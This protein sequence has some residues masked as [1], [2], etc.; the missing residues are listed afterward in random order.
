MASNIDASKPISG[1]PTTASVR[2][3]FAEAKSEIEALQLAV[4]LMA[5]R[6]ITQ[7][8]IDAGTLTID[9]PFTVQGALV[10]TLRVGEPQPLGTWVTSGSTVTV[11]LVTPFVYEN[12]DVVTILACGSVLPEPHVEIGGGD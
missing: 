7:D 8:M 10:Q 9:F 2:A 6:T 5:V 3:N 1:T 12:R 4:P 11:N